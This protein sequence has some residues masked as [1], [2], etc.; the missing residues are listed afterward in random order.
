MEEIEVKILEIDRD[1]VEQKLRSLGAQKIF[2]DEMQILLFETQNHSLRERRITLRVRKEGQKT[3]LTVKTLAKN[4]VFSTAKRRREIEVD[5]SDFDATRKLL[6]ALGFFVDLEMKKRRISYQLNGVHFEIDQYLGEYA[7][8]PEFLEIE[9]PDEE[10]IF[11]YV[12]LLGFAKEECKPWSL[13]ELV[14]KYGKE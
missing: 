1:K 3:K 10:T 11:K 14:Q 9:G 2:D 12:A 7:Y 13:K 6:E 4:S 5:V 8:I